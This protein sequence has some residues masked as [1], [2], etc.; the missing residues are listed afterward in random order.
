MAIT[1]FLDAFASYRSAAR[2]APKVEYRRL[3]SQPWCILLISAKAVAFLRIKAEYQE[4]P[5]GVMVCEGAATAILVNSSTRQA[6]KAEPPIWS[7][8]DV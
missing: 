3:Y 5:S 6:R 8:I 4:N 7:K 1:I 2:K